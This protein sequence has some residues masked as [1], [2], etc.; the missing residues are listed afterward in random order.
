MRGRVGEAGRAMPQTVIARGGCRVEKK[1]P[2]VSGG[3]SEGSGP[4]Y[5][6]LLAALIEWHEHRD[7]LCGCV[8]G[9]VLRLDRDRV[10]AAVAVPRTLRAEVHG[11]IAG[12]LNVVG[13]VA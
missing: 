8:A 10:G 5:Q 12:D 1:E 13:G 9:D 4:G 11:E 3:L 6:S 7:G 2:A